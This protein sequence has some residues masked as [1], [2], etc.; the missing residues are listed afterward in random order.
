[1]TPSPGAIGGIYQSEAGVQWTPDLS[2]LTGTFT[3]LK[4]MP[5]KPAES[6]HDYH[7]RLRTWSHIRGGTVPDAG[8]GLRRKWQGPEWRAA[9]VARKKERRGDLVSAETRAK[10]ASAK[11][12]DRNPNARGCRISFGGTVLDFTTATDAAR[13]YGVS[14]QTMDLWLRKVVPWPGTGK[15]KP[16]SGAHLIGM[17]GAYL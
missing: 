17:T 8:D 7:A 4:E 5:R 2:W 10:M 11:R 14:Q 13:H 3:I 6:D 12:G 15:R 16:R 9:Q 1:M